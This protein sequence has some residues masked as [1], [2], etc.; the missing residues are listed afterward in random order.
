MT[1]LQK[2]TQSTAVAPKADP[3]S[4]AEALTPLT[5]LLSAWRA[6]PPGQTLAQTLS[7]VEQTKALSTL[8]SL[9]QRGEPM[10][11]LMIVKRLLAMYPTQRGEQPD[12]VAEDW[13]RVLQEYPIASVW[14][15]YEKTIRKPG[16]FA[17]SLGDF[18]QTVRDHAAMVSRIRLSVM[19]ER[20]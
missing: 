16:Q 15:A 1:A 6:I 7:E 17:P 20:A 19:G 13:V 4:L 12:S 18:L 14:A 10:G 5:D 3:E 8:S 2:F 11:V 9:G